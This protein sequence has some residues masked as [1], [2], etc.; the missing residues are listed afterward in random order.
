[1]I[2]ANRVINQSSRLLTYRLSSYPA[3][4]SSSSPSS[5]AAASTSSRTNINTTTSIQSLIQPRFFSQCSVCRSDEDKAKKDS[6]TTGLPSN[7]AHP[8]I[9]DGQ[10]SP[11]VDE[12]GEPKEDVPQDV[13]Q[14]NKEMEERHDRAYNRIADGGK[15]T[16]GWGKD[17]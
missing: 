5:T 6:S 3:L 4:A 11:N 1:M 2:R 8:T 12:N 15:T 17:K 9:T 7:K 14:H 10:Q 16:T 13:K